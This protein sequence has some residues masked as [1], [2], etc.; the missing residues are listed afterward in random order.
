MRTIVT[1]AVMAASMTLG[2]CFH[3]CQ[4]GY[5]TELPP[6]PISTPIK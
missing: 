3:H 2:G 5:I 1:L 6:P 4:Q